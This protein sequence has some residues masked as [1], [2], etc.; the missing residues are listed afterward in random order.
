MAKYWKHNLVTLP[1]TLMMCALLCTSLHFETPF[2]LCEQSCF[3]SFSK[4]HFI[5][6]HFFNFGYGNKWSP[7]LGLSS[8]I[9]PSRYRTICDRCSLFKSTVMLWYKVMYKHERIWLI[10]FNPTPYFVKGLRII[11][12]SATSLKDHFSLNLWHT[13]IKLLAPCNN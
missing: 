2:F 9:S 3:Q 11:S 7:R 10:R 13:H 5:P 8:E 1:N 4:L 6:R 12:L